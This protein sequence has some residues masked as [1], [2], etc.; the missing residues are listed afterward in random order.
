MT[1]RQAKTTRERVHFMEGSAMVRTPSEAAQ[2]HSRTGFDSLAFLHTTEDEMKQCMLTRT[3]K[4]GSQEQQIAWLPDE[5]SVEGK[6]VDVKFRNEW[7]DGWTVAKVY[8]Q[9]LT[10]DDVRQSVVNQKSYGASIK[11]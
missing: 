8:K 11:P 1:K 4:Y 7:L 3:S 10:Y 2:R 6:T 5:F 9:L